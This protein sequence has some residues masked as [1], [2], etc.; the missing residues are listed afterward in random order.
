MESHRMLEVFQEKTNDMWEMVKED[1]FRA[2]K[3]YDEGDDDEQKI[4]EKQINLKN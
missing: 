1:H 4:T 2:M 3:V